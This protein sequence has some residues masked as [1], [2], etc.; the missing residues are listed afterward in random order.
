MSES[1]NYSDPERFVFADAF[2][3]LKKLHPET[4]EMLLALWACELDITEQILNVCN[5]YGLKIWAEGGTMLGAIRHKGFIP[6]DDDMD[7]FMLRPDYNKLIEIAPKEFKHPYFFQCADTESGYYRGHAQ[8][9]NSDTTA[10]I[11]A[12]L[13][14]KFN[15]GV[16]VDIFVFDV[17]PEDQEKRQHLYEQIRSYTSLLRNYA[18]GRG[19]Y[20]PIKALKYGRHPS[21]KPM[22]RLFKEME[23]LVASNTVQSDD[24]VS[25]PLFST[26][27]AP[28][29][30]RRVSDL[31]KT[32]LLDFEYLKLPVPAEYDK[33]LTN[34]YGDYMTPVK[35]N[36]THGCLIL[37]LCNNY[38]T[39]VSKLR[40]DAGFKNRIVYLRF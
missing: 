23:Q 37:D 19:I 39:I 15:Q 12:D 34:I 24:L 4:D 20:R 7:F 33:F 26:K 32:L 38:K 8:V 35:Q 13:W 27:H 10:I 31:D 2:D 3:K 1:I 18:Y 21:I 28:R 6:W 17:I 29:Y 14:Q 16:F 9:R 11:P 5:K 30:T 40:K 22:Y 25:Y 36:T